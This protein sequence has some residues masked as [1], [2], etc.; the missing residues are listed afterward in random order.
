MQSSSDRTGLPA[1]GRPG[2]SSAGSQT[3]GSDKKSI[4]QGHDFAVQEKMLAPRPTPVQLR[5]AADKGPVQRVVGDE[6]K[7]DALVEAP[8]EEVD[9]DEVDG[10]EEDAELGATR[11]KFGTFVGGEV[12]KAKAEVAAPAEAD[13]R[14][15]GPTKSQLEA[16][17][18]KT[19]PKNKHDKGKT[20]QHK[21]A[22][23]ALAAHL[24][25]AKL[26]TSRLGAAQAKY[27]EDV[28]AAGDARKAELDGFVAGAGAVGE[29]GA[30][31]IAM[32][33]GGRM[34]LGNALRAL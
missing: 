26:A 13:Y 17:I 7:A 19:A 4:V 15:A 25:E 34:E 9:A 21:E 16:T 23:E 31:H 6:K 28:A 20:K 27:A 3:S 5:L 30:M 12:D 1:A 14:V 8:V 32:K 33:T 22:K 29:K 10:E 18:K 24:E 11:E 2:S